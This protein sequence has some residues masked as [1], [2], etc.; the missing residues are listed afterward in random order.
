MRYGS[1][2][3]LLSLLA[4][5]LIG[6]PLKRAASLRE[7]QFVFESSDRHNAENVAIYR[8]RLRALESAL[9]AGDIDRDRFIEDR[10]ELERHLLEDA[11]SLQGRPL[12]NLS[13][14]RWLLPVVALCV[15]AGALMFYERFGGSQD[16]A[17][18]HVV[19]SLSH[20]PPEVRLQALE[21]EARRQPDNLKYGRTSF[22]SIGTA[23]NTIRLP[24][25]SRH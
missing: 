18:Y 14:G 4:L 2:I 8:Q 21:A 16:L 6:L 20:S 25:S 9:T 24:E 5:L 12:D 1:G 10:L 13:S 23:V 19:R 3:G 17:L 22:H 7:A 15:V 11:K